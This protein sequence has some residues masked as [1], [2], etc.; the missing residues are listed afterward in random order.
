MQ[1]RL[2]ELEWLF[3]GAAT[4]PHTLWPRAVQSW[5][6]VG[7]ARAVTQ[8]ARSHSRIP[9]TCIIADRAGADAGVCWDT[10]QDLDLMLAFGPGVS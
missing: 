6:E 7:T 8:E 9:V 5:T 2:G 4:L 3:F 10:V 1:A